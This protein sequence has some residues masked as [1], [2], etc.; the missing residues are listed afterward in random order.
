MKVR[1]GYGRQIAGRGRAGVQPPL[2][3]SQADCVDAVDTIVSEPAIKD[4]DALCETIDAIARRLK[5]LQ[6]RAAQQYK[7]LVDDIL[8]S[9]SCDAKQIEHTLNGTL[10]FYNLDAIIS[11][12]YRIKSRVATQFRIWA[13]QR[14][15]ECEAD[16]LT[17][18]I[19]G[20]AT[21]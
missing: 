5:D 10:D 17:G 18:Q 7:P 20:E 12:A 21:A 3:P 14:L 4:L 13:T 15:M 2:A 8:L 1:G 19:I 6:G 16:G 11:V 9:R